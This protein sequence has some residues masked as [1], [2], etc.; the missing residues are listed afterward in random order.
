MCMSQLN[1]FNV[2]VAIT[3]LFEILCPILNRTLRWNRSVIS[4]R[5][6][7][8]REILWRRPIWD[9]RRINER[10]NS[11]MLG[12]W[13]NICPCKESFQLFLSSISSLSSYRSWFKRGRTKT[14]RA[15]MTVILITIST[16]FRYL[17]IG[18]ESELFA[19]R[20]NLIQ[21]TS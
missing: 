7:S 21:K 15:Y 14:F 3:F 6:K 4:V 18:C 11:G 2:I 8:S 10:I 12:R 19:Y 9:Q 1:F 5:Y 20:R 16:F 13:I 17:L